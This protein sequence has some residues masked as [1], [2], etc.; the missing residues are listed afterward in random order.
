MALV[1]IA[2]GV[3][4][5]LLVEARFLL[6][7]LAVAIILFS[8]TSDAIDYLARVRIGPVR[9]PTWLASIVAVLLISTGLFMM[10]SLILSQLNTVLATTLTYTER[11]PAA[12]ASLFAWMGPE[13]ED[14]IL[15]A[16][17]SVDVSGYLRTM[18]GQAGSLMQG[19]VLVILFVGFLFA[20]KIWFDVKLTSLMG[21]DAPRVARTREII[22][23]IMHRVNYYLLVKTLVSA[24]TGAM[25]YGICYAFGLEL[26]VAIGVLTFVLN[27]I[28]NVG[29]IVAT[30]LATLVVY[31]QLGE[32]APTVAF[33]LAA[34]TIQ[35]VNGNIIDPWLM[36][37]TLRLSTFGIIVSLAFWG[38]VW[39]IEGM[40]L[41]VP[42]MVAVMIVCS[43]VPGLRTVAV[44]LSR[45]GLPDTEA[46]S[47][48]PDPSDKAS[49]A[50]SDPAP[51]QL[52][53]RSRAG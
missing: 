23:T 51:T 10:T 32:P 25:V 48:V 45:E 16:M 43:H 13:V 26:A 42:I 37:R 49:D 21:G 41:S 12:V 14:A 19:T 39:G 17:R 4:L 36:G 27:Y 9:I 35:F 2:G 44:M 33:F 3:V 40:F 52:S 5:L 7:S 11:A 1:I 31:V 29:S 8:L 30:V 46:G 15:S 22:G 47:G 28:P 24:V 20:E 6:A 18:A 50:A 34:G 53:R 38:A